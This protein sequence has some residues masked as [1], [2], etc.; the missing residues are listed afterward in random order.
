MESAVRG[1]GW[2]IGGGHDAVAARS[3]GLEKGGVR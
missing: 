3:L 2:Q 1:R